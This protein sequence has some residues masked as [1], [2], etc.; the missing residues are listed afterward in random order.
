MN[1]TGVKCIH[2]LFEEQVIQKREQVAIALPDFQQNKTHQLTYRE[3]DRRAN[4]L[5]G[6]LQQYNVQPGTMVALMMV[7]SLEL[8]VAILGILKAGAV[9]VPLDPSY[10]PERLAWM[11]EDSQCPIIITQSELVSSLPTHQAQVICLDRDWGKDVELETSLRPVTVDSA[12]LAYI[13]YTSGS[14]G[15]PKG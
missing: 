7:R 12:S 11:L 15:K 13:N 6:M 4:H 14:T 1:F 9:Y 2:E 8:I 10:P 3:L 5:A